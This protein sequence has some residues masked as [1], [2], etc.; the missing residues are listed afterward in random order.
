MS[1][2]AG[3]AGT[4]KI[5]EVEAM[6][7]KMAHRGKLGC[8]VFSWDG[9]TF[10]INWSSLQEGHIDAMRDKQMVA[11]FKSSG[12]FAQAM[13]VN[14]RI[15]LARDFLGLAPLY[16]GWTAANELC[17]AS[18]V[19]ALTLHTRSPIEL[20]PG[21]RLEQGQSKPYHTLSQQPPLLEPADYFA[22]ELIKRVT[23]AI[24]ES[25]VGRPL[26]AWLSGG[27]DSSALAALAMAEAGSLHTFS[28]GLR[29][30]PDLQF[31]RAVASHIRSDHHEL[32][33][34]LEQL[35]SA[36][37]QVIYHLESFDA[38]LVRSSIANFLVARM[39]A[40]YVSE[41]FSGE[42]A[43]E[44]LAG[45]AYLKALAADE[46]PRELLDISSRLHNTALQR[47]DRCAAAHGTDAHLPF[48]HPAVVDLALRMP[49]SFKIH[50][51]VEKWILR[52]AMKGRLPE[53]VLTRT[54]AKFWEG[55]GIS[56]MLQAYADAQIS[57]ADFNR[58][59]TLAN[60]WTLLSKEE[61]MYYR[62]FREQ[63]G[64]LD[65]LQW[66]GR[67]KSE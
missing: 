20:R 46:L 59:R 3:M 1:A 64:D 18:E 58:E 41:V 56:T 13:L 47:V 54:K 55:A 44:L 33:L 49:V 66:M 63:L 50:Q 25:A 48:L 34:D 30:A 40:D 51:N 5:K 60:G 62:L 35:L 31:A 52:E 14:G 36:L 45:Y 53:S 19:K 28:A 32:T 42:G 10:G 57:D 67:S 61:L 39:A 38:L 26:G 16:Y 22:R 15:L 4:N 7:A 43:D 65:T 29:D 2:I 6:L 24:R 8:R 37:P 17:F 11:D 21:H 9:A 27:L 12:H 23:M